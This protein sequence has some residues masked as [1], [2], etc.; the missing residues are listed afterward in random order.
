MFV[1][2]L[3]LKFENDEFCKR[4]YGLSN[5]QRMILLLL[6]KLFEFDV[7]FDENSVLFNILNQIEFAGEDK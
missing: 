1:S 7:V 2:K 3:R 4:K 5:C 6:I